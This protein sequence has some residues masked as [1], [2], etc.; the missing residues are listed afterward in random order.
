V[1]IL[2]R[3]LPAYLG[4]SAGLGREGRMTERKFVDFLEQLLSIVV[5]PI[6][7]KTCAELRI[8]PKE[9]FRWARGRW[10][11]EGPIVPCQTPTS[12]IASI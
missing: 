5:S 2:A 3:I 9:I 8:D 7:R 1:L 12:R 10:N 11:A 4:D 6:G